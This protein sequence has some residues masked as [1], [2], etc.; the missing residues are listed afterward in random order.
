ML[1]RRFVRIAFPL[2]AITAGALFLSGCHGRHC[3]WNSS[4]EKKADHIVKRISKELDL[5]PDQKTKLDKIKVDVLARKADFQSVHAG[6]REVFLTQLRSP[7]LDEAKLNQGLED[8]EAKMK[9]LRGFLVTELAEFHAILDSTQ[10]EKLASRIQG[11]C[12]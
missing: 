11:Y 2:L 10:R 5:T 6:L 1:V 7:K 8:R 9:E 4:P 3:G 12:R